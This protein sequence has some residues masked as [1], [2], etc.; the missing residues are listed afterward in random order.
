MGTRPGCRGPTRCSA[1]SVACALLLT[2]IA[3][4]ADP[5]STGD[6]GASGSETADPVSRILNGPTRSDHA[7]HWHI[8]MGST[9]ATSDWAFFA[10]GTG[11]LR[12]NVVAPAGEVFRWI[13]VG[14]DAFIVDVRRPLCGPFGGC[15]NAFD[16]FSDLTGSFSAGTFTVTLDGNPTR[17][18]FVLEAGG[19]Y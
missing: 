12:Q 7:T 18:T 3:A 4:C 11:V 10:D 2:L 6:A 14:P 19:L 5:V 16:N 17:R 13:Q 9:L 15:W 8:A 1:R